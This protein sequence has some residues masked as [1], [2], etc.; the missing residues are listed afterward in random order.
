M[1]TSDNQS[2]IIHE[3]CGESQPPPDA[4]IEI[5]VKT[6]DDCLNNQQ[7]MFTE[8]EFKSK[9]TEYVQTVLEPNRVFMAQDSHQKQIEDFKS[10]DGQTEI[11][12]DHDNETSKG[13]NESSKK[14]DT[15]S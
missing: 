12:K 15:A 6:V 1:R 11:D 7:T 14:G 4:D 2:H 9:R 8:S 5:D 13:D 10:I 3:D